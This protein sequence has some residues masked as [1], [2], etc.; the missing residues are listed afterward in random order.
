MKRIYLIAVIV[1][2]LII[3]LFLFIR[4]KSNSLEKTLEEVK[5]Y[6]KYEMV[7]DMEM[8]QNDELKSYEV[9]VS[10]LKEKKQ[11]YYKV[12]LLS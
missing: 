10:Y 11:Q 1:V 9:T 4:L 12:E 7:C 5:A 2:S 6:T 8:V 3:G